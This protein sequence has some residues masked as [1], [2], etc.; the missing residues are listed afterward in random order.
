[1]GKI[2]DII[3]TLKRRNRISPGLKKVILGLKKNK[4][5]L[6]STI[7]HRII[8]NSGFVD[9]FFDQGFISDVCI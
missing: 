6:K 8:G 1:M 2:K 4:K 7:N 9:D 5:Q 3:P